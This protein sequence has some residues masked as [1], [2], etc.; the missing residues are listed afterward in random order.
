MRDRRAF[1][2]V[3]AIAAVVAVPFFFII[4]LM[5]DTL[6]AIALVFVPNVI[7]T[8]WYGPA[9]STAQSVVPP[10]FRAT[11]AALLLLILN[12]IGLLFGPTFLGFTSTYLSAQQHMGDAEGLRWAMILTGLFSF[13]AAALFW[14]ARRTI[15]EDVVS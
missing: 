9:Y 7:A 1:V 15:R 2:S 3:P 8:I 5:K 13:V 12:L 11:S 14:M 6:P 4:F 10:K